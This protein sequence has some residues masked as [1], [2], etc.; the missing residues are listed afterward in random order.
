MPLPRRFA[1]SVV[2]QFS[3]LVPIAFFD[4][5]GGSGEGRFSL[6]VVVENLR[7]GN[8]LEIN[9][10]ERI[11]DDVILDRGAIAGDENGRV[12]IRQLQ[13]G[14]GDAQSAQC[15]VVRSDRDDVASPLPRISAPRSPTSVS[16]LLITIGPAC[17]PA[18]TRSVSPRRGSVDLFLE[19]RGIR[20][21][22]YG[23]RERETKKARIHPR[24]SFRENQ[25]A[26]TM[27]NT[28]KQSRYAP[29]SG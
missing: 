12:I 17:T 13:A 18:S 1:T 25:P 16:G 5:L 27:S 23:K 26:S 20:A 19:G 7:A 29:S 11:G 8:F 22:C 9:A 24:C 28:E 21:V 15:D 14:A 6:N 3:V 2:S 10:V 4:R